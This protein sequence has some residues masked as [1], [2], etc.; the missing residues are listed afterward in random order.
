[1][2]STII[3]TALIAL[4]AAAPRPQ[5]IDLNTIDALPDAAVVKPPVAVESDT[6]SIQPSAAATSIAAAVVTSTAQKRDFLD[7][8]SAKQ[9]RGAC[10]VQ[11]DGYGPVSRYDQRSLTF[12]R[13]TNHIPVPILL[14]DS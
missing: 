13:D 14:M 10:A 1:M 8:I 7:V 12:F 5:S 11:P 3:A 6:P 9:K 2:R 4:A